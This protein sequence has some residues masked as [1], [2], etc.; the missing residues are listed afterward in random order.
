[1]SGKSVCL[2]GLILS[3]LY[4]ASPVEVKKRKNQTVQTDTFPG[5]GRA[6]N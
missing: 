5:T 4:R 1:G 6:G 3:L 2:N